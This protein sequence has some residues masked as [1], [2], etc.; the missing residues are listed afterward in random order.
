MLLFFGGYVTVSPT[1]FSSGVTPGPADVSIVVTTVQTASGV[2]VSRWCP[3][4]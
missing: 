2:Y 3:E 4:Q 1:V